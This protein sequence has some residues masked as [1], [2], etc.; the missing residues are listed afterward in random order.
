MAKIKGATDGYKENTV[1]EKTGKDLAE[2]FAILDAFEG[3]K[4]GHKAMADFLHDEH[5]VSYWWAQNLTIEY[6]QARGLR[7]PGQR[8]DGKF[9]I[10]VSRT[11]AVD[12]QK[13][14][15]AWSSAEAWDQWLSSGTK[16]DFIEGGAYS[17]T[18]KDQGI[19]KK[20]WHPGPPRSMSEVARIEFTWE[21]PEHC[22]GSKVVVQFIQKV[23]G[24]CQVLVTHD[25]LPSQAGG[26]D[27]KEGWTWALTCLKSWLEDGK[28]ITFEEWKA[29]LNP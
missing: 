6:E 18:D 15:D 26:E 16:M 19:F 25:K 4:K 27:M 17:N 3:P 24:K 1:L 23:P 29:R 20:I 7:V 14:F 12:A 11:I 5:Q 10:N 9:A 22:P 8:S 2:W 28:R 21:N 13:A